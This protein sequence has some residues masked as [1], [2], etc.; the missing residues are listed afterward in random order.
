MVNDQ[1]TCLVCHI[2]VN[3]M[4]KYNLERHYQS[5]HGHYEA[6]QNRREI[7]K[8][9]ADEKNNEFPCLIVILKAQ[10]VSK[11]NVLRSSFAVYELIVKHSKCYSDGEFVK[12]CLEA[13]AT[14]NFPKNT[15]KSKFSI[16]QNNKHYLSK[17]FMTDMSLQNN[18]CQ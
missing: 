14:I 6:Q 3:M 10:I 11:T 18:S 8:L 15:T 17:N 16:I 2:V 13:T 1:I 12:D 9:W 4:K 7:V 5:C